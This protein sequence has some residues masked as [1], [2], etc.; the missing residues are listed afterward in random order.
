[1]KQISIIGTSEIAK[2]HIKAILANK[3]KIY[4]ISTTRKNSKK[5]NSLKK[6]L[7]LRKYLR[8][9][10]NVSEKHQKKTVLF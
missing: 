2:E 7:E 3:T 4:S 9:G 10:K 8:I 5:L 1:M 6:N